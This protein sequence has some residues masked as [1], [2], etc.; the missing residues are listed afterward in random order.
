MRRRI[1]WSCS[2]DFPRA[3]CLPERFRR[4][5]SPFP[6]RGLWSRSIPRR[7]TGTTP[8]SRSIRFWC[9]RRRRTTTRS[10]STSSYDRGLRISGHRARRSPRRMTD[11]GSVRRCSQERRRSGSKPSP[12]TRIWRRSRCR[13]GISRRTECGPRGRFWTVCSGRRGERIRTS[14]N[15][16]SIPASGRIGACSRSSGREPTSRRWVWGSMR[17]ARSRRTGPRG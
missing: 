14:R 6:P 10:R 17:S 4:T 1:S 2:R 13:S 8:T 15:R 7:G 5:A 11:S 12:M 9:R 3:I 16:T